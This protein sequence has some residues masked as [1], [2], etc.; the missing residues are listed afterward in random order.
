[1]FLA[2]GSDP[3]WQLCIAGAKA[4]VAERGAN[5]DVRTPNGEGEEGLKE[6]LVW[7]TAIEAGQ[8]DGLAIGPIDPARQTTLINAAAEKLPVVTVDSDAPQSRR[9]FFIGSSN[10]EAGVIAANMVKA[11]LPEGGKVAVLLAS[12][13]K[14]NAVERKQGLQE[15]L[16]R[17]ADDTEEEGAVDSATYVLVGFYMDQGNFDTCRDNVVKACK[18]H[19]DLAAIVGTFGYHGPIV[20][21]ALRDVER[22]E[23]IKII[24]FDEDE[25]TLAA[26]DDGRVF[27]T[28][29]QDPFMFGAEAVEM[30][31]NVRNGRFLSLPVANGAVGVHCRAITKDNIGEFREQLNKR[32][33]STEPEK[34]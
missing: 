16:S 10:V 32:L 24:A 29:V 13:A 31:E 14:T 4:L 19:E 5:L 26:V 30:L 28:I 23:E 8:Y 6:Q 3:Y 17:A 18:E 21:E 25:R 33:A 1:L 9:M 7:L 11:A 15:T 2:G 22:G 12:E 20:L 27:A 34:S